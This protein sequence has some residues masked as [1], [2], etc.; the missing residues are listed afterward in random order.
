MHSFMREELAREHQRALSA[1]TQR[2]AESRA[3][4]E[5]LRKTS[6][7]SHA[8][9]V[10]LVRLGLRLTGARGAVVLKGT[11][12]SPEPLLVRRSA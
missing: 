10:R 7:L 1:A 12:R 9:G 4:K 6:R 11:R 3:Y 5:E 2:A 8:F